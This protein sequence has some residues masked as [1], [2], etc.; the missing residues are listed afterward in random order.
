M[1]EKKLKIGNKEG[2]PGQVIA[3]FMLNIIVPLEKKGIRI[4]DTY[5]KTDIVMFAEIYYFWKCNQRAVLE[6]FE[7]RNKILN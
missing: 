2:T 7:E 5:P 1:G 3:D 4:L 6:Y